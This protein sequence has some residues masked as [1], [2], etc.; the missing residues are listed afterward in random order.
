MNPYP[1]WKLFARLKQKETFL[2]EYFSE[3]NLKKVFNQYAV[4]LLNHIAKN[5]LLANSESNWR[6]KE[7]HLDLLVLKIL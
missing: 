3:K 2:H 7:K 6:L 4:F 5:Q 1:I